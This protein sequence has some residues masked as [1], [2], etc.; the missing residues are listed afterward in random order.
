MSGRK[1]SAA[2]CGRN[3]GE[4][5]QIMIL[6]LGYTLIAFLL[7]VVA[8]DSTAVYLA[9]TQLRD[10]ADA[11]ALDAADA[12]YAPSVYAEGVP[13]SVPLSDS[14][15]RAAAASYLSAYRPP[16]RIDQVLIAQPTGSPDGRMA[17]VG[18]TGRVRLPMLGPVVA[19]WSGGV[20]VSVQ[21]HARAD[22]DGP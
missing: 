19:A 12:A 10:A 17:V 16:G 15:V 22:V 4:E 13:S 1:Q 8:V 2:R 11:A 6:V 21:A 14:T 20:T 7:V 3:P 5:G 18:L 9:R